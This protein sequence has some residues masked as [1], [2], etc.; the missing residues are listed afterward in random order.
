MRKFWGWFTSFFTDESRAK[1]AR[2]IDSVQDFVE[3]AMPI[4]ILIDEKL[5]PALEA[6]GKLKTVY[7]F[8]VEYGDNIDDALAL[9]EKLVKLP[10]PEM[11]SGIAVALLQNKDAITASLSV[12]KL[13]I[14]LAYNIYKATKRES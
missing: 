3:K 10:T 6:R 8:L 14:E 1:V 2:V 12:L 11:L 5:K 9:A 7:A 4:V 13:S